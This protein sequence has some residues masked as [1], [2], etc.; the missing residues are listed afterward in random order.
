MPVLKFSFHFKPAKGQ[1]LKAGVKKFTAGLKN[2]ILCEEYYNSIILK[3]KAAGTV[4]RIT[5]NYQDEKKN[6]SVARKRR[7]RKQ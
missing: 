3:F 5:R 7:V 6:L 2:N 4:S 1:K